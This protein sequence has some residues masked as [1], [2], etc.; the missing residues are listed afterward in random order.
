MMDIRKNN[1]YLIKNSEVHKL[2]DRNKNKLYFL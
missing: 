2:I 1:C